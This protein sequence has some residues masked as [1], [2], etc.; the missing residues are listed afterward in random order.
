MRT[1]FSRTR[2][3]L[4]R[5]SANHTLAKGFV[6]YSV[7][8]TNA[9]SAPSFPF[10]VGCSLDDARTP[11]CFPRPLQAHADHI[12][13]APD[14]LRSAP[15]LTQLQELRLTGLQVGGEDWLGAE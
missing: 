8:G 7:P 9:R 5:L 10:V 13:M 15:V 4:H 6:T 14:V 3:H 12:L 11:S 2:A 1:R